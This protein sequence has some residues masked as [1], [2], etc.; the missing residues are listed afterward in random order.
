MADSADTV[1][2]VRLRDGRLILADG[3]HPPAAAAF[4][5]TLVT[6]LRLGTSPWAEIQ[7][8]DGVE[9]VVMKLCDVTLRYRLTGDV[10]LSGGLVGVRVDAA[11][12]LWEA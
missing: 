8:R 4:T 1:D 2:I 12:N 10:D 7:N 3:C 9:T 5:P 11:G 6:E